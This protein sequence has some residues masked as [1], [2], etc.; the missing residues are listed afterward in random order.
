MVV[1]VVRHRSPQLSYTA[2][3]DRFGMRNSRLYWLYNVKI[4]VVHSIPHLPDCVPNDLHTLYDCVSYLIDQG[5]LQ[6]AQ[7]SSDLLALLLDMV[8]VILEPGVISV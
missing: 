7:S 4:K 6:I 2:Q 8:V 3:H 1:N 5:S